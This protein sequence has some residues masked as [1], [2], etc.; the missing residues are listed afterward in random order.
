MTAAADEEL[1]MFDGSDKLTQRA[2]RVVLAAGDEARRL[3]HDHVG[4]E[5]IL[6]GLLQEGRGVAAKA[7]ESL[8]I[9]LQ[10]VR[11]EVRGTSDQDQRS[12]SGHVPL[13]TQADEVLRS[14][15]HEALQLDTSYVGTEHIL[16]SLIS[17]G[18]GTA[19]QVLTR[20]GADPDRV[21][22][23]VLQVLSGL[24]D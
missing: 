24:P 1:F 9:T 6:L 13:T 7:L 22:S 23:R 14:S 10:D 3:G 19:V 5:H 4:T 21:R 18:G 2:S 8:G 15:L 20:L 11:Q 16:L 17:E 12:T